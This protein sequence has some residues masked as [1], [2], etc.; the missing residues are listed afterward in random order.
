MAYKDI[1]ERKAASKRHYEKNK[2][3]YLERNT[4]YRAEIQ[5]FIRNMEL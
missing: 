3:K 1:A 2:Q 5:N 4:K